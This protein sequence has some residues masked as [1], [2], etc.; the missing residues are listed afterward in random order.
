MHTLY[1][2]NPNGVLYNEVYFSDDSALVAS[3]DTS[4]RVKNGFPETTFSS[5]PIIEYG[6]L[7]RN[8]KYYW[9]VV[10][11]NSSGSSISSIYYFTSFVSFPYFDFSFETGMEGWQILG[12][13][14]ISNWY[15]SNTSHTNSSPGE[16]VFRW[17]PIFTG[18]SYIMSPEFIAPDGYHQIMEFNYYEDWWSDTVEV[19][20]AITTDNGANWSQC[21]DLHSNRKCWVQKWLI[22]FSKYQENFN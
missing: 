19:G 9:K 6:T 3:S 10:E 20:F 22:L 18:D 11:Y 13:L 1:W 4:I 14:G 5:Y 21:W 2:Q 16:M 7:T 8:T 12:P 17:D 15:W